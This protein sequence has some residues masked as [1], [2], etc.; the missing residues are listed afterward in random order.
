MNVMFAGTIGKIKWINNFVT[1]MDNMLQ[2]KILGKDTKSLFVPVAIEKVI[3]NIKKHKEALEKL[4]EEK[5]GKIK[6]CNKILIL[7]TIIF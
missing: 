7:K 2:V 4:N 6:L 1:F 5:P 3:I